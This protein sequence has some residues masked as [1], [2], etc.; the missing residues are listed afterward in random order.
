LTHH[1]QRNIK[2]HFFTDLYLSLSQFALPNFTSKLA[3]N[4][5][6]ECVYAWLA[7]GGLVAKYKPNA[8]G[9]V[10]R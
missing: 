1:S 7:S 5:H 4:Q 9:D 8:I 2:A 6:F 3:G 10:G